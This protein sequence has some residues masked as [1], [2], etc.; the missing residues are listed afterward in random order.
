MFQQ[1]RF[2]M[3][4]AAGALS[5]GSVAAADE[6]IA[7]ASQRFANK[8]ISETPNFQQ[9][10]VPLLSR[11]GCNGRACHGSFQGQGGFRLSLFG[12]DFKL[13]HDGLTKGDAE[14]KKEPRVLVEEPE[15]SLTL[16]KAT[17]ETPHRG[18]KRMDVDS[19]Q[20]NIFRNWIKDGAR[21]VEEDAPKFVRLDVTPQ[22]IQFGKNGEQTQLKAVAVWSN[23]TQ[24]DVTPL[25][26]FNSNDEVIAAIDANGLVKSGEVGD[27]HVVV[28][29]DAGVVPIPVIRPVSDKAGD[30]YPQ[31]ATPTKVDELVVQKLRK[32]GIVSSDVCEDH[33]FLRRVSLDIAGSLPHPQEVVAFLSDTDSNKRA[34][35]IDELLERPGYAAWWATK[36]SDFTGNNANML[37][38]GNVI[39]GAAA[40]QAWYDWLH[41]RVANNTPYDELVAGIV[42][43]KSRKEGE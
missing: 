23:G 36:L 16:L 38:R 26:R 30:K 1:S 22:E 31:I 6:I 25:C 17:Q 39:R 19:W 41:T 5:L 34:K 10:V 24:E 40:A 21:T 15:E 27:T 9:H 37:N 2:W 4:L 32:L 18:G 13:D 12:Y 42:A 43:S 35:K 20:Y 11:L 33:E 7:P 3:A 8:D 29:Y 14:K 28:N